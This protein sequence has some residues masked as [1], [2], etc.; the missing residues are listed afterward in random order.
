MSNYPENS[1]ISGTV[2]FSITSSHKAISESENSDIEETAEIYEIPHFEISDDYIKIA[3]FTSA[4]ENYC[5]RS[6]ITSGP[7]LDMVICLALQ[8]RARSWWVNNHRNDNSMTV[9]KFCKLIEDE[10][11]PEDCLLRAVQKIVNLELDYNN[12]RECMTNIYKYIDFIEDRF[13]TEQLVVMVMYWNSVDYE[14]KIHLRLSDL[15]D[16]NSSMTGLERVQQ[17]YF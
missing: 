17:I 6:K 1:N 2:E 4:F 3:N 11:F 14:H 10:Y 8:G 13:S 16:L 5:E 9:D 12:L 15:K 7:H